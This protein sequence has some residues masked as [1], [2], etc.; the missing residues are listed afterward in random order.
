[1]D[2]NLL[3]FFCSQPSIVLSCTLFT[4]HPYTL[5]QL[6]LPFRILSYIFQLPQLPRPD[7][8][9]LHSARPPGTA[10]APLPCAVAQREPLSRKPHPTHPSPLVFPVFQRSEFSVSCLLL[11]NCCLICFCIVLLYFSGEQVW[12]Q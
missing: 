12:C 6:L 3:I 8:W 4:K 10:W 11:E 9:L 1:M 2:D 7:L 5:S